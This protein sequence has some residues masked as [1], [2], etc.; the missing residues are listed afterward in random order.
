MPVVKNRVSSEASRQVVPAAV[1]HRLP[2]ITNLASRFRVTRCFEYWSLKFG[3]EFL[4]PDL[5][6][7]F[8]NQAK[9]KAPQPRI[10]PESTFLKANKG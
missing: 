5:Y 1:D 3:L 6:P 7:P 10:K 4:F 9:I 8:T 2:P